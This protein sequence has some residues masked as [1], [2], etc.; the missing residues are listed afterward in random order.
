MN[1]ERTSVDEFRFNIEWFLSKIKKNFQAAGFWPYNRF[2][3]SCNNSVSLHNIFMAICHKLTN[4]V[5]QFTP[6]LIQQTSMNK[7]LQTFRTKR[8]SEA[9]IQRLYGNFTHIFFF[10]KFL[11]LAY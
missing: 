2:E 3:L 6:L 10:I 5:F 7:D 11:F 1:V 8:L 4:L 9:R